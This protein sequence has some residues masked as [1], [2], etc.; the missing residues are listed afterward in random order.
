MSVWG[1][2]SDELAVSLFSFRLSFLPLKLKC[3]APVNFEIISL[4]MCVWKHFHFIRAFEVPRI[5]KMLKFSS[6]FLIMAY[7]LGISIFIYML[8]LST[9]STFIVKLSFIC[10]SGNFPWI[11][12]EKLWRYYCIFQQD[13][14]W[15]I[16]FFSPLYSNILF[17]RVICIHKVWL[18]RFMHDKWL[19]FV[20]MRT[21]LLF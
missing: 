5:F 20:Y 7:M 11:A 4:S 2:R 17:H 21:G 18:N 13:I 16:S 1:F 8:V 10:Y 3:F 15:K 6:G 12:D 9:W 14:F 19:L